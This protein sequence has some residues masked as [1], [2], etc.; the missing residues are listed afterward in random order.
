MALTW[1]SGYALRY[2]VDFAWQLVLAGV[3]VCF[4]VHSRCQSPRM[5]QF[6][7]TLLLVSTIWCLI[8]TSALVL[9]RV[10]DDVTVGGVELQLVYYRLARLLTFWK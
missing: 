3:L 8:S 2:S 7:T 6:L 10:P 4:Y 5:K 1:E 9:A